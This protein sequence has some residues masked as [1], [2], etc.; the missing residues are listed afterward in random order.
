MR[1]LLLAL[2]LLLILGCDRK[3][4]ASVASPPSRSRGASKSTLARL[5]KGSVVQV[6]VVGVTDGDTVKV[7]TEDKTEI[8]MRL[9]G[10]DAP[11]SKMPFGTQAKSNLSDLVFNKT[12]TAKID[13]Y[14]R[15]GRAV[16]ELTLGGASVNERMVRDGYAWW[17]R[18]Y[19][20]KNT[21]LER[22]E[23]EARAAKRGLWHDARP[24]APWEWRK[25]KREKA[26]SND[27]EFQF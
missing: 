19:A 16:G 10:I 13:N 24:K 25:A 5:P 7:L 6:R 9:N 1:R 4:P 27:E 17:Y 23:R 14:D 2:P 22:L 15:Y 18:A 12:V 20:K 21:T 8:K 26:S 3:S 11:E